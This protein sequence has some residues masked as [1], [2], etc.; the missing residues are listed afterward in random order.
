MGGDQKN[1]DALDSGWREETL[2]FHKT[3]ESSTHM[4]VFGFFIYLFLF[5]HFF[6]RNL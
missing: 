3:R 2:G 5:N 1:N 6:P 4:L